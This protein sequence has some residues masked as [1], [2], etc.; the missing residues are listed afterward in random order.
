M[1]QPIDCLDNQK[2]IQWPHLTADPGF[3]RLL[4]SRAVN[5]LAVCQGSDVS[6]LINQTS[7]AFTLDSHCGK[8]VIPSWPGVGEA[9]ICE[10]KLAAK[11]STFAFYLLLILW[12]DLFLMFFC[13]CVKICSVK[14]CPLYTQRR[15]LE[16]YNQTSVLTFQIHLRHLCCLKTGFLSFLLSHSHFSTP[17]P[18]PTITQL[19]HCG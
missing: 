8:R 9:V 19:L 13:V 18:P 14:P 10:A 16:A 11:W 5:L 4:W 17:H 2:L 6:L 12:S 7:V 15:S 3:K 1:I